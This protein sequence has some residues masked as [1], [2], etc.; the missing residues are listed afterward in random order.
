MS[1]FQDR[2]AAVLPDAL[3]ELERRLQLWASCPGHDGQPL[4]PRSAIV[5]LSTIEAAILE[6]RG[7]RVA[8]LSRGK[9]T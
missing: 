7:S 6:I 5:P 2:H 1:E 9:K 8:I 4:D 3:L